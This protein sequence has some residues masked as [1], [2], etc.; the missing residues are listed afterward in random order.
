M[1]VITLNNKQSLADIARSLPS[2]DIYSLQFAPYLFSPKGVIGKTLIELAKS[3]NDKKSH[4]N[5][6]EIWI[7][8]Y[9]NASIRERF[10]GWRQKGEI[11]NFLKIANP[12]TITCSNSATLENLKSAKVDAKYLYLFGNISYSKTE[13][14]CNENSIKVAIF[15]TL[16]EKFPYDLLF[17]RLREM[18]AIQKRKLQFRIIGRQRDGM[19]ISLLKKLAQEF[20]IKI[21]E[22]GE[23]S[24]DSISRELQNCDLGVCTTPYDI[25]G[26]SGAT[27]AMLEHSLPV[28]AFD[29]GDTP[30]DK[31]F[32]MK[33]FEDQIFLLNENT[34]MKKICSFMESERK[35]FFNGVKRTAMNMIDLIEIAKFIEMK[36]FLALICGFGF[37]MICYKQNYFPRP[38]L[39]YLKRIILQSKEHHPTN[40]KHL[41]YVGDYKEG[42][43]IF[44]DRNY[45]CSLGNEHFK[46]TKIIKIPRHANGKIGVNILKPVRI[47]RPITLANNNNF[48]VNWK[49][50]Y[51][52]I[53]II[54]KT[55]T[56]E[57]FVYKD[58]APGVTILPFGGPV[59]AD[60]IFIKPL[61]EKHLEVK[62]FT[63]FEP[64]SDSNKTIK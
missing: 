25:I 61:N 11:L 33:N 39:H 12:C 43:Q 7:G 16:Y 9:P 13:V 56:F 21:Y 36:V 44:S 32:V 20:R 4:V 55:C 38:Q 64:E 8:S 40:I 41:I 5:F 30:K 34:C 45:T 29:D 63:L 49:K 46:E 27:A 17:E 35:P 50:A 51:F 1:F 14:K 57:H 47:Y 52:P 6:H 22:Y 26:K 60:P 10:T 24:T 19:G 18:S 42:E 3:L 2:S 31:L 37:G 48:Y 59:S 23:L 28:I 53:K 15:G 58:F 54:S 62:S